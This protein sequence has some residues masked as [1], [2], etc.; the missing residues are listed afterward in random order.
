LAISAVAIYYSVAGLAAIF[1]AAVIPIIIMG[2]TLE[3]A[4]LV[5]AVWL[6]RYWDQARWWLKTYLI[7]AVIVLMFITSMGIFGFLSKAHIEQTTASEESVAQV[8]QMTKEIARQ[9]EIIERAEARVKQI[10]T[11]GVGGDSNV[12]SQIQQ[13]QGRIDSAYSRVQPAI[14]EQQRIIDGQTKIYSDAITKIDEQSALLQRYIDAKEIDKAQ[15]LVGVKSDGDWGPA[16]ARAVTTWKDARTRERT[17]AVTKL[18][19]AN[20][21]PTIKSARDE[22]LRIRKTVETQIAESNRLVNRLRDQ[23]GKTDSTEV[24]R[25]LTEQ[26]DRI[27]AAQK[28]SDEL[29][30]KKYQLESEYRKLEAEVG[31]IKYIAAMIYGENTDSNTLEKA[32]SWLIIIIIFVFDPLAVLLLLAS[33]YSYEYHRGQRKEPEYEADDGPLTDSQIEQIKTA[34]DISRGGVTGNKPEDNIPVYAVE[35]DYTY[36][37]NANKQLEEEMAAHANFAKDPVV[38][39]VVDDVEQIKQETATKTQPSYEQG[40]Y[41]LGNVVVGY[42]NFGVKKTVD[43][44]DEHIGV[45]VTEEE[46]IAEVS[47]LIA[48]ETLQATEPLV[49]DTPVTIE[50]DN[51]TKEA[52]LY[53]PDQEYVSHEGKVTSINALRSSHPELILSANDPVNQILFG[54]QFPQYSRIGDI[55]IRTDAIPHRVYKFNGKKWINVDK[56]ASSTYLQSIPYVNYLISKLESG[57]YSMDMLTEMERE[58][59]AEY[60]ENK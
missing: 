4:K 50:T 1:A 13:E 25:L 14:D 10:E 27:R 11:T 59:I 51:V 22:I 18:E 37:K 2:G 39:E 19:E 20:N 8:E 9:R 32:V 58:D 48:E 24:D 23:L 26:Q 49:A 7:V 56:L 41:A 45:P 28:Q 15:A 53:H 55:Y 44:V 30:Q 42:D 52:I 16:T 5:T 46:K 35:Q 3:I 6:H 47:K 17:A 33:Q 31:P 40:N 29:T 60:L 12:Q 34:S 43:P 57:E 38:P 21:N 36:I 54:N